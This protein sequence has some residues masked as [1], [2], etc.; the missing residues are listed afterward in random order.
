MMT[1]NAS[2]DF[3]DWGQIQYDQAT[4]QQL[5]LVDRVAA[6][7]S[8]ETVIFC[9]HSPVVTVG[10]GTQAGDVFGWQGPIIETARGGRATY[11]GPSQIVM[12]PILNLA[13]DHG[14]LPP[15]DLHAYLR[16]LEMLVMEALKKYGITATQKNSVGS[17]NSFTGVWV[18]NRKVASIGVAVRK[19]VT[20]HGV[21]INLDEDPLAFQGINPCGF[22]KS[23]MV[24]VQ[25]L[26]GRPVDRNQFKADLMETFNTLIGSRPNH[27]EKKV[28]PISYQY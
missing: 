25:E 12:Y 4:R 9:T 5:E 16:F 18:E 24:P 14:A 2:I 6:G 20:Y 23:T 11:H 15:R 22:T 3:V 8:Q 27:L 7:L 28:A 10:R 1:N 13:K 17:S 21:A 19:W 26:L